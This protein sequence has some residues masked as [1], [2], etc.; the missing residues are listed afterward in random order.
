L[1]WSVPY[2]AGTLK[3]IAH[4][5]EKTFMQEI[6]TTYTAYRLMIDCNKTIL[7]ADGKDA[8]VIN[9][10]VV[11]KMGK[12]VPD[13]ENLIHFN[14]N[15]NANIIGVGNG[16][17]SSHEPDKCITDKWQ[18]HLFNGRAQ[19]IVQSGKNVSNLQ[20]TATSEGLQKAEIK[21]N[22]F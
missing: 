16:D 4:K 22:S 3:A 8:T 5:G 1:Q 6:S 19:V 10:Y 12:E 14:L 9:I 2:K 21:L 20:F 13:A 11:D 18:R 7:K 15:G 17:P